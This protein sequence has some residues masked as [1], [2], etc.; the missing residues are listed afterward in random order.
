MFQTF[1]VTAHPENGPARLT[2]LRDAIHK[3]GLD[4]FIV[5]RAD[6]HQGE[7]VAPADERLQWLTGFTGSAGFGIALSADAGVFIDGRDR[8]QVLLQQL[9]PPCRRR[10]RTRRRRTRSLRHAQPQWP[11]PVH[12]RQ[13]R[14]GL[15]A[16][17]R[18][19][20]AARLRVS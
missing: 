3:A 10:H 2:A 15:E 7:Y 11:H 8:G 6:I 20:P 12:R 19:C 17:H 9:R 13:R 18:Q 5:P 14:V 4:G 1:E 16:G